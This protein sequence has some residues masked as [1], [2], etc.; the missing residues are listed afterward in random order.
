MWMMECAK[1]NDCI[2]RVQPWQN[3]RQQSVNDF[4]S[5]VLGNHTS[6]MLYSVIK[7]SLAAFIGKTDCKTKYR[8]HSVDALMTLILRMWLG[9]W[10]CFFCTSRRL[11]RRKWTVTYQCQY[12]TINSSISE[13]DHKYET[14]NTEPEIGTDGSN[15]TRRNP[16]VG[17]YGSGFGQP[18]V[19]GTGFWTVL[20][21][22]RPV[23]AVQTWTAGG[24]PGPVA[25]TRCEHDQ[26]VRGACQSCGSMLG[27]VI[28]VRVC[29]CACQSCLTEH[30][31]V[32]RVHVTDVKRD[33]RVA[34]KWVTVMTI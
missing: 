7:E 9:A 5:C 19:S 8:W 12:F 3:V 1:L 22:N 10:V 31:R 27:G 30:V 25:N 13:C 32:K 33:V 17:R 34:N 4:W 24:L 18:R 20:E 29:T 6:D 16:P 21:P 26:D 15:Q 11:I 2:L 14:R 23:F 28:T